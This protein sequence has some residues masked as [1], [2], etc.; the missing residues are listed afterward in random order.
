MTQVAYRANLNAQAFPFVSEYSGRSIIVKQADQNFIATGSIAA[1]DDLDKDTG[2]PQIY[3]CH[4]V[5]PT[6]QGLQSVGYTQLAPAIPSK[7]FVTITPIRDATENKAYLGQTLSGD[8]YILL[9]GSTSWS[10]IT[11]LPTTA[12]TTV[13]YGF[14]NGV[15]YLYFAGIGCY[16]YDFASSSL[17]AVTLTG[18]T[19][20]AILGIVASSGYL[21]AWTSSAIAWSSLIDP[22]DFTPSLITG[23]GGGGVSAAKGQ[24]VQCLTHTQGFIIY[25]TDNSVAALF[26][27]NSRYPFTFREIVGSSGINSGSQVTLEGNTTAHY[28]YTKSGFQLITQQQSQL[29]FPEVTDFISGSYFEDFN[30]VTN[31]FETQVVS[32]V[33]QK[34]IANIGGRYLIISYGVSSLTHCLVFDLI[35]KRFG[36]LKTPHVQCFEFSSVSLIAPD[37]PRQSLGFLGADGTVKIVDFSYASTSSSGVLI[38]GKYQYVRTRTMQLDTFEVESVRAAGTFNALV[39]TSYDGKSVD[40]ITT[41]AQINATS[42]DTVRKYGVRVVGIN[43]SLLFKGDFFFVSLE[44]NFNIHGRR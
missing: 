4:N 29:V 3:Y 16:K 39:L 37:T 7:T 22:T 12:G 43:H 44:L 25:T 15:T 10:P 1:K 24:L 5:M 21:I 11:S 18:L 26:S 32:G 38:L 19:A 20:S 6:A 31:A 2:I 36:K 40:L 33:M 17:L 9:A 8:F 42:G 13:T 34:Q 35:M 27:N 28:A 30:E 41:A 23:A 14:I